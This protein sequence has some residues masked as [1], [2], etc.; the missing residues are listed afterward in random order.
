MGILK[1]LVLFFRELGLK[2]LPERKNRAGIEEIRVY[3]L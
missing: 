2:R 1:T 3:F